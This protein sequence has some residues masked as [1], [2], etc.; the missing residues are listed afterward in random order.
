LSWTAS[1]PTTPGLHAA[2]V[3]MRCHL[4]PPS[5]LAALARY[6]S[7][8]EPEIGQ[9]LPAGLTDSISCDDVVYLAGLVARSPLR[10]ERTGP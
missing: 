1:I 5:E 7:E 4:P 2:G 6:G 10:Q 8:F 3:A 9:W